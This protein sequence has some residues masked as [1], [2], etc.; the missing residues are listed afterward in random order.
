[1]FAISPGAGQGVAELSLASLDSTERTSIG[2][3]NS[4][5]VYGAGHLLF[6]RTG[7]LVALPL[8]PV[9]RRVT[10]EPWP[11]ATPVT[12]F[13]GS[14]RAPVSVSETGT[15]VYRTGRVPFTTLTWF[16]RNGKAIGTIEDAAAH[17]NLSLSVD[18]RRLAVSRVP[19]G[20]PTPNIDIWILDLTRGGVPSR[21]TFDAA[22]EF[23]PA[24]SPDGSEVVFS[25]TRERTYDLD[26]PLRT[27]RG[28]TRCC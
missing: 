4:N 8:D 19:Q 24:L 6:V 14:L 12:A 28:R 26:P 25:S 27:A 23:D 10:G 20:A 18:E 21:L 22:G 17:L 7:N 11:V 1:M 9:A 13:A 16:D 15:L 5:A 3:S 2:T